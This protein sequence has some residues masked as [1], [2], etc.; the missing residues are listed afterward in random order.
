MTQETEQA[1]TLVVTGATGRMGTAVV[2]TARD[3]DSVDQVVGVNRD[4][5]PGSHRGAPLYPASDLT[6]V[7]E[8]TDA[9]VLIDF[10]GPDSSV[11]YVETATSAGVACTVGTTGFDEE[12][13]ARL[14]AASED[15][16]VLKAS[17][18]APGVQAM[19]GA[20]VE[21]A[22]SLPDYDVEVTGTYHNGKTDAPSGTVG[23]LVEAVESVRTGGERVYGRRGE[24]SRTKAEIGVHAR[25]AG[26]ITGE[27]EI[28]FAG[29]HEVLS[30]TQRAEDRGVFAAGAVRAAVAL[31]GK[32]PGWYEFADVFGE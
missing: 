9:D 25:R 8:E 13:I 5:G 30:I 2:S 17:N 21:L 14:R 3:T 27:N 18:F 32:S 20:V 19:L 28:L 26:D 23:S 22:R 31:A 11:G 12:Q 10:T 16:P 6:A 4:S 24:S 7:L 1:V 29:N 15:G